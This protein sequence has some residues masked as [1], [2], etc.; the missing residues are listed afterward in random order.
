VLPLPPVE[1]RDSQARFGDLV[2]F[3]P[4]GNEVAVGAGRAGTQLVVIDVRSG[5][6]ALPPTSLLDYDWSPDG[7]WLALVSG[8]EIVVSGP[9]RDEPVF[10]LPVSARAIAWR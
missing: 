2:A 3:S 9:V 1:Y 7:A 10:R 5:R 8:E 6:A 4:A